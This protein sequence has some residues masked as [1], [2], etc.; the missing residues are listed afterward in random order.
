MPAEPLGT[1]T[2]LAVTPVP[3]PLPAGSTS[4]TLPQINLNSGTNYLNI[5]VSCWP[6]NFTSLVR[7]LS[8]YSQETYSLDPFQQLFRYEG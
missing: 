6:F 7:I 3:N 2:I 5:T 1:T 4:I 8:S